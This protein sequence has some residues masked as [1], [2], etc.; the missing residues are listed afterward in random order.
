MT[1][2]PVRTFLALFTS[3]PSVH[4]VEL[5]EMLTFEDWRYHVVLG[6]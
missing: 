5:E 6:A 2:V 3:R 4:G 1:V